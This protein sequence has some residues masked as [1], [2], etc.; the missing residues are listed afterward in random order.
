M[1][2]HHAYVIEG[3]KENSL[4]FVLSEIKRMFGVTEEG[5]ADFAELDFQTM[6]IDDAR[7]LKGRHA[8]RP[9]REDSYRIF[10]ILANSITNEAQNSLLKVFEEPYPRTHFFLIIP[11]LGNLLLTLKSR[12]MKLARAD[13]GGRAGAG[14]EKGETKSPAE[15]AIDAEAKAF[16]NAG[17]KERLSQIEK[18]TKKLSD[19]KITKQD[20]IT[21]LQALEATARHSK[22]PAEFTEKDIRF[23][24][25]LSTCLDYMRDRSPSVKQ[26][27]EY[28][29]LI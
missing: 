21:F 18:L 14:G 3:N 26:L 19:E 27:L 1:Q 8:N 22:K 5:N 15:N 24:K 2:Y 23:F 10:V 12:L 28:L 25:A 16:L 11:S 6:T 4:P 17:P 7:D 13:A 29:A 9:I 20:I